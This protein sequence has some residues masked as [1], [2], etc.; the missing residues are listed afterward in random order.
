VE[1]ATPRLIPIDSHNS[2]KAAALNWVDTHIQSPIGTPLSMWS[3]PSPPE[4]RSLLP[5][6]TNRAP[7]QKSTVSLPI[8]APANDATIAAVLVPLAIEVAD[9]ADLGTRGDERKWSMSVNEAYHNGL[10]TNDSASWGTGCF[11]WQ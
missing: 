2:S 7:C 8:R 1:A 3:L 10:K 11:T 5:E 4:L 9:L 6:H